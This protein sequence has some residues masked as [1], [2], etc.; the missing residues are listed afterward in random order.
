MK[1]LKRSN[2][3]H[4]IFQCCEH[5]FLRRR[6]G[7]KEKAAI[8]LERAVVL[9]RIDKNRALDM[10]T[11]VDGGMTQKNLYVFCVASDGTVLS[12]SADV[13]HNLLNL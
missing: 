3:S 1:I 10:F 12:H 11:T 13:G 6:I 5:H 8:L 7:G 9:V 4:L 2:C